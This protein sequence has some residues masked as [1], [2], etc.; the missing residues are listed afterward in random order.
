MPTTVSY[1]DY[2][3]YLVRFV[4]SFCILFFGTKIIIGLTVPEGFYSP[5][6]VKYFNYPALLRLSLFK[7]TSWMVSLAG[8]ETFSKDPYHIS[9]L[10]GR[11][12]HLVYSCLGLGLFSCWIAFVFAHRGKLSFKIKWWFTGCF[13]IWAL[14]VLRITILLFAL[15]FRWSFVFSIDHHL[16][17]NMLV[18]AFII[19]MMHL[20]NLSGTNFSLMGKRFLGRKI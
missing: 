1:K 14:N 15:H 8:F 9:F 5:L 12:I 6:V 2:L 20:F 17:F 13:C 10:Q 16:V 3:Y 11:G 19:W 18:Y 4:L 7:A